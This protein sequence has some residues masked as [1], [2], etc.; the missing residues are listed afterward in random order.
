MSLGWMRRQIPRMSLLALLVGLLGV[1]CATDDTSSEGSG[2]VGRDASRSDA[3][4]AGDA[5]GAAEDAALEDSAAQLG[6]VEA[7]DGDVAREDAADAPRD[8]PPMDVERDAPTPDTRPEE[9]AAVEPDAPEPCATTI[10]YGSAWI[11]PEGREDQVDRVNARVT[12]DG[13]CHSDGVNAYAELSNGW[14]PYFRGRSSCVIA[15]DYSGGCAAEEACATRIGYGDA[16]LAPNNHPDRHDEVRGVVNWGDG[17]C[18]ATGGDSYAALSNGWRPHFRGADACDLSFRY[19]GCGG[20]YANPVIGR[21]CPDPGVLKDGDRYILTC[22]GGRDGGIFPIYTSPDLVSWRLEGNVFP[23]GVRPSWSRDR[24]WAP[25]IHRVAEGRYVAYFSASTQADNRLVLGA[26]VAASPTGPFEDIGRPL[27]GES[28]G[29]IDA[30]YVR[31][32]DGQRYLLWKVDG[33]AVGQPTPIRI[34]RLDADGVTLQGSPTTILTNDQSWEGGLVEGQWMVER[35]GMFYLFYSGNGYATRRYATGVA[36]SSSPLGPFQKR[37]GTL[38]SSS[39]AWAGPGHG[40][41]VQAPAGGDVYVYH[42]WEAA[43]VGEAP[44]RLTLV[45]RLR[46]VDGW[47]EMVGSPSSRSQPPP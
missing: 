15:L 27:H 9:D 22:T 41:V 30:H 31:T 20:L 24:Y 26:A 3:P 28:L 21:D 16:W 44:G 35:G 42:A 43:H 39:G 40:A 29:I 32:S 2:A 47:P 19:T 38:L 10:T 17:V 25:E 1:A 11:R 45:D 8:A 18:H 7:V 34:Q 14:R 5:M 46:W 37:A 23:R 36:R 33:N 12:W 13:V 4:G 6:D